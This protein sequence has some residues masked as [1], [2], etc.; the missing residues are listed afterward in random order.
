MKILGIL[1]LL[2]TL[3]VS[4]VKNCNEEYYEGGG[5][6]TC[7]A[8]VELFNKIR[9]FV[10]IIGIGCF[11]SKQLQRRIYQRRRYYLHSQGGNVQPD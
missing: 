10:N 9:N 8:K 7:T 11:N 3:A 5:D 2:L 1:S 4:T 6:T